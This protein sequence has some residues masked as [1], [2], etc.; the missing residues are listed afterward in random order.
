M[1]RILTVQD[2]SCLGKC[3]LTVALPV[4]SAMGCAATALPT[5]VLSSHTAFPNPHVRSLTEDISAV[6]DHWRS[7][8]AGFDAV[9]I[10]YLSDPEQA[11]Q[12][13]YLLDSFPAFTVLDPVMGDHG[14]RYTGIGQEHVAAIRGLCQKADV[15]LPNITEACLFT[16]TPYQQ[17]GDEDYYRQLLRKLRGFVPHAVLTGVSLEPGMTGVMTDTGFTYQRPALPGHYHGTGDLFTAVFTGAAALGK[18]LESSAELAA[19]FVEQVI[20]HTPAPT[21]FGV[22]FEKALPWLWQ[23]LNG[24]NP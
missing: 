21:P 17:T 2:L 11:Q 12:A 3:S 18:S 7:I 4:L 24:N 20:L 1:K 22:C 5:A 23:Q 6:C 9:S 15:L 16:D 8:G 19:R 13:A 14:K 10:G